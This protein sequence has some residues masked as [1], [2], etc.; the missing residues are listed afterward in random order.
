MSASS[1]RAVAAVLA[2]GLAALLVGCASPPPPGAA[3]DAAER[4]VA[5]LHTSKCNACHTAPAPK[6]RTREHL[7]DA[8]TRHRRRVRLTS[9]EWAELTDYLAMPEGKTARQP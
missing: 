6:T 3:S 9:E 5:R 7:E 8:F 1:L 4:D 2:P